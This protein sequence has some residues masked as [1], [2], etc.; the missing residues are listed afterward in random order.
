MR[1]AN[2]AGVIAGTLGA[3]CDGVVGPYVQR[4]GKERERERERAA[5]SATGNQNQHSSHQVQNVYF[6]AQQTVEVVGGGSVTNRTKGGVEVFG[7]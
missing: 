3:A 5:P 6:S 1:S 2:S 7:R 4:Q